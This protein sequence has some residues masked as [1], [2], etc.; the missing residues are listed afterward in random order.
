MKNIRIFAIVATFLAATTLTACLGGGKSEPTR[1]YTLAIENINMPSAGDAQNA[2]RV[3]IRKFTV[4]AAYQRNNIVYRE[5]AYDFMFYDLDLWASRP[6]NLLTQLV[7]E[8]VNQSGLFKPAEAKPTIKPDYEIVGN[9][10][11]IEEVDEGTNRY[12]HLALSL[13]FR[14]VDDANALWEGRFDEKISMNGS[15]PHHV[16]EAA[17]KLLAKYMERALG[18]IASAIK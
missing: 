12:V 8:Y 9:V 5:S 6:D 7:T 17:S 4:E 2:P 15:E 3:Q 14:K 13:T 11:A 10:N 16:A 18:E 1:Y